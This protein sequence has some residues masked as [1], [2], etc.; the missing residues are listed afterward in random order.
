MA[1]WLPGT[2]CSPIGVDIGSRSVKLLQFDAAYT[3]VHEAARWD[4][5]PEPAAKPERHDER[6]VEAIRRAREGRDFRGHDA[7]LCLG[8]GSLFVQN[9]RVSQATG[10]ELAKIVHFEA[11][12]RLPFATEEAEIRFI[13]A[14]DVRQG[15]TVRR[16][17]ILLACY[18]PALQRMLSRGRRSGLAGRRGRCRASRPSC[19][20]TVA[21]FA[22][23]TTPNGELCS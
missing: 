22:A 11:A 7:V 1:N 12:G 2:R 3:R 20:A 19:D 5:P 10:D 8:A 4:L 18:R 14:D 23:T 6:L 9:I 13:E 21:N 17:V 16:E 15:D